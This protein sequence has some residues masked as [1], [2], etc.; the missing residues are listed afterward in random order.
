MSSIELTTDR[1][2]IREYGLA[3]LEGRHRLMQEAFDSDDTP[4]QTQHW[5]AWTMAGYTEQAR[6]YQPPYGD[7]AVARRDTG[8]VVGTVGLVPS[9]IPWGVLPEFRRIDEGENHLVVPEPGLFWAVHTAHR[10]CGYAAEAAAA[11]AQWL[12]TRLY[13]R[14]VVATTA[15]TNSASQRVMAKLG[16]ALYR[17]PGTKPAW[18]QVVGVLNHP[19][20]QN[21][22]YHR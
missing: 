14:R 6:L 8:Q 22:F 3:D 10:G 9:L 7:Y 18:F 17:N 11:L 13:F 4:A 12:F 20:E 1:L 16:M 21:V 15:A 5:L 19:A 2:I